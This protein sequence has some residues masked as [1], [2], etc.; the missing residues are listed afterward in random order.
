MTAALLSELRVPLTICLS[1]AIGD[2][3]GAMETQCLGCA[4]VFTADL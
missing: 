2:A 4:Q 1:A 3:V